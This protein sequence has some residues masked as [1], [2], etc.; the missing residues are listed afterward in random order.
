MTD[1]DGFAFS[2]EP[3][4][5]RVR[6]SRPSSVVRRVRVPRPVPCE[7]RRDTWVLTTQ[8]GR[9]QLRTK[10]PTKHENRGFTNH[11]SR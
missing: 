10:R 5:G 9:P 4:G 6:V 3:S 1:G 2:R 7:L 8:D 11:G